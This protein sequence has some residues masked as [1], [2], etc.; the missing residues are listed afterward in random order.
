MSKIV[1]SVVVYKSTF[2]YNKK[3]STDD[4][5]FYTNI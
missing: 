4:L 2:L 3:T 5:V 1:P